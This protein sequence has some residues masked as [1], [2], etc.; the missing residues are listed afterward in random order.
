MNESLVSGADSP[1][2]TSHEDPASTSALPTTAPVVLIVDDDDGIREILRRLLN[3]EAYTL[4]EAE[5]GIAALATCQQSS[6][7]L[8]LLDIMM[9]LMDGLTACAKIRELPGYERVPILM[10]TVLKDTASINRAFEAG[11]TDYL[12][13]PIDPTILRPRVKHLLRVNQAEMHM[14]ASEQKFRS[15]VEQASDGFMLTDEHGRIIEWN[16]SMEQITGYA[17]A[18]IL[19]QWIWDVQ[20][21]I[22]AADWK[23]HEEYQRLLTTQ[24]EVY[25]AGTADL[26][27]QPIEM[28]LQHHDGSHRI[29]QQVVFL[30]VMEQGYKRLGSSI[31]DLTRQRQIAEDLAQR[32]REL[33]ALGNASRALTS[34]LE[35]KQVLATIIREI[36]DLLKADRAAVLLRDAIS[37]DL[38]FAAAAGENSE[39]LIGTRLAISHGIA[40]WV[41]RER[42]SA[43]VAEAYRDPRFW[44]A[45]DAQTGYLT[46]SVVAVPIKY[47]GAVW[48]VIEAI[49]KR[50]G[51]FSDRDREMLEA[52]AGSAAIALE[53][54]RLYQAEREQTHRL[55][56]SQARLIHAE[57]M[58]AL[59]RLAA[60]LTHEINNPLQALRSGL[61]LI[62]ADFN[63][64]ADP[65]DMLYDLQLIDREVKRI[66]DLMLRLRE[67]SRPV[68]LDTSPTDLHALLDMILNLT[69]KQMQHNHIE[70]GLQRDQAVPMIMASP[71]QLT[72]VFMNLVLN[73][74]DAMP[75]GGTLKITTGVDRA[76]TELPVIRIS[77]SDT[78]IGI[79]PEV[80]PRIFEPFFTTK[81]DG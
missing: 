51:V 11:A 14:R 71:D 33:A 43:L 62:Q 58:S 15:F 76:R 67:F 36:Q 35:L 28:V 45:A 30:I 34:S 32:V 60:S 13:K 3:R 41:A 63:E 56:E 46:R 2:S 59:G 6:V 64:G 21:Q 72:Q 27:N 81:E 65:A 73:A 1:I 54:A 39:K 37:D 38:V 70:V 77:V 10:L 49:N 53:N 22:T 40:G 74:I 7:D 61:T 79:L 31:R 25:Q 20:Q 17:R 42:Q 44:G 23:E 55:K 5:N 80:L 69:G 8:I 52:L 29:V 75:G 66:S 57:K 16:Q 19:G 68:Q 9:P 48:G 26:L 47:G 4:L 50:D 78:G 24:H 18:D 12:T